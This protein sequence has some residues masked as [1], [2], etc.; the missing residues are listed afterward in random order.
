MRFPLQETRMKFHKWYT[1][2]A[3]SR[4]AE[5]LMIDLTPPARPSRVPRAMFNDTHSHCA[6][7]ELI[8]LLKLATADDRNSFQQAH[9]FRIFSSL[10]L[11]YLMTFA[12][13]LDIF[14]I[15]HL[16]TKSRTETDKDKSIHH[17]PSNHGIQP[18]IDH[19]HDHRPLPRGRLSEYLWSASTGGQVP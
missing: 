18:S 4:S 1:S 13:K 12:Q 16:W 14:H 2:H 3:K 17:P 9:S 19:R 5:N 15:S 6:A 8:Q 7:L 11:G 10:I